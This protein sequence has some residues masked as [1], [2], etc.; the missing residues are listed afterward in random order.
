MIV[1][2]LTTG[3]YDATHSNEIINSGAP[4]P[5]DGWVRLVRNSC[6]IIVEIK[7]VLTLA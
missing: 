1:E 2:C 4:L 7:V 6:P 3:S 5:G